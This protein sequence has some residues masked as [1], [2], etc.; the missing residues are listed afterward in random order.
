MKQAIFLSPF[1]KIRTPNGVSN[2]F[3]ADFLFVDIKK[4]LHLITYVV[5]YAYVGIFLHPWW[6]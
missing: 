5:I 2:I 4:D 3:I 6:I 1:K